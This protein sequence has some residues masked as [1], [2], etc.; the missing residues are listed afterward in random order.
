MISQPPDALLRRGATTG[1]QLIGY[2]DLHGD[3]PE[4]RELGFVVG[5]RENWNR[6]YGRAAAATGILYGFERLGLN[7]IWAEAL[8]ANRASIRILQRI[9]MRE[10]RNG[11]TGHYLRELT[12][13][14][15]FATTRTEWQRSNEVVDR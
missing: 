3:E 7:E 15:R 2:V 5:G 8:D 13:F 4:G 6:G 12:H 1:G 9:G 14:R 10:T 11:G